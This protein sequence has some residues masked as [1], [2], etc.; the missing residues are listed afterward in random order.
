MDSEANISSKFSKRP[1]SSYRP[2]T[3]KINKVSDSE[4]F[5]VFKIAEIEEVINYQVSEVKEEMTAFDFLKKQTKKLGNI[6]LLEKNSEDLFKWNTILNTKPNRPKT[7]KN[8]SKKQIFNEKTVEKNKI[9]EPFSNNQSNLNEIYQKQVD[10]N[11]TINVDYSKSFVF[12]IALIDEKEEKLN[13]Y[14]T[15]QNERKR[16]KRINR[17]NVASA[18]K[19]TK[20]DVKALSSNYSSINDQYRETVNSVASK[21]S[22]KVNDRKGNSTRPQSVFSKRNDND[23]FYT[24]K[25]VNDYFTQDFKQFAWK[26]KPLQAKL[27]VKNNKIKKALNQEK[28]NHVIATSL[29]SSRPKIEKLFDDRDLKI[30]LNSGRIEPLIK[31]MAS[32]TENENWSEFISAVHNKSYLK[33]NKPLGNWDGK[34]DY[35]VNIR[36][37]LMVELKGISITY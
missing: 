27:P 13:D 34:V 23:I 30:T 11:K 4:K 14:I 12:P 21:S 17:A 2:I 33:S 8:Y 31:S 29:L 19:N 1:F 10:N 26:F 3:S 32:C 5:D 24:N 35:R 28:K 15:I 25:A 6:E 37:K 20:K 9:S 16:K 7:S 36:N 22:N 18:R